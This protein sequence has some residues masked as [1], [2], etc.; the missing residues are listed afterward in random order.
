MNLGNIM[1][2]KRNQKPGHRL[3]LTGNEQN[4]QSIGAE[5]KLKDARGHTDGTRE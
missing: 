3:L 5:H 2:N 4:R 1:L